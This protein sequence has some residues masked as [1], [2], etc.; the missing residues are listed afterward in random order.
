VARQTRS[1]RRARREAREASASAAS[2]PPRRR[3][4][5]QSVAPAGDGGTSVEAAPRQEREGG[6][7]IFRF[8]GESYAELK[9]VDWPTQSQTITGT[10]VVLIACVIVGFYLYINDEVWK[11]VV[12][13]I[14]LR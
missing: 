9:K 10:T 13:H 2:A 11:R 8:I 3:A 6:N 4:S 12:E 5:S 1:Q 7:R 14:F